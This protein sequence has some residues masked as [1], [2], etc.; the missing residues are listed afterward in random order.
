MWL[1]DR[2]SVRGIAN[3][4]N[5]IIGHVVHAVIPGSGERS[6]LV[7]RTLLELRGLQPLPRGDGKRPLVQGFPGWLHGILDGKGSASRS[8]GLRR[9]NDRLQEQSR[10]AGCRNIV[11]ERLVQRGA[12]FKQQHLS[13]LISSQT[14]MSIASSFL[15]WSVAQAARE[16]CQSL[17]MGAHAHQLYSLLCNQG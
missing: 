14:F 6:E 5:D 3:G 16:S 1:R 17:P 12:D 7:N 8:A 13:V 9:Y 4:N 11:P 15:H 10:N 2:S